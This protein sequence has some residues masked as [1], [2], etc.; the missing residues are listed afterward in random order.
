M[1][2]SSNFNEIVF[3]K[4][5]INKRNVNL[6]LLTPVQY[7][8]LKTILCQY[9]LRKKTMEETLYIYLFTFTSWLVETIIFT[10]KLPLTFFNKTSFYLS[11]ESTS[12]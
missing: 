11:N 10:P 4:G 6:F 9:G 1:Q 8:I 2:N 12:F 5:K 7:F 3:G